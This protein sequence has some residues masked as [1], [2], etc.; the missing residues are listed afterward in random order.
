MDASKQL[1]ACSSL[2]SSG[3]FLYLFISSLSK[4]TWLTA[5]EIENYFNV[6]RLDASKQ[7][8]ACLDKELMNK[9][10]NVP[11]ELKEEQE[12]EIPKDGKESDEEEK[13]KLENKIK[14]LDLELA[15]I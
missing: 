13:K 2:S 14:L 5:D 9:Y 6:T 4:E 15:L 8:V 12:T 1:V 11:E 7:L 10:K 3:T